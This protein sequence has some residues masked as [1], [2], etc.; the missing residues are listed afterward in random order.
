[1]TVLLLIFH[2]T[3]ALVTIVVSVLGVQARTATRARAVSTALLVVVGAQTVAGDLLYPIYITHAKPTLK[4]LAAGS[5]SVAE[6][7]EVKEH[8][9][10]FALVFTIGAFVLTR[11]E[12]KPT[13]LLRLL[14]G[15]V[16]G[17]VV[18]VTVLGL[19]VASVKTP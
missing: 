4:A 10:F 15:C 3:L 8:L 2:A 11:G 5:R 1:V 6:V 9:A 17:V 12:P 14:F 16:H 13:P 19:V 18:V 7:F